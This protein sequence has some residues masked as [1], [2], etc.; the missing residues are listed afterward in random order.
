[1]TEVTAPQP[2]LPSRT[3]ARE[4]EAAAT[5]REF[6]AMFLTQ[7]VEEML[8]TVDMGSFGGGEAEE[9]W[10]GFLAQ[11]Y[12]SEIAAGGGTG[13]ARSVEASIEAYQARMGE[14]E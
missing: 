7:T 9:I 14:D 12:A 2:A 11:A 1:M 3:P 10:R 5:A 4:S 13:I 8:R 6:E